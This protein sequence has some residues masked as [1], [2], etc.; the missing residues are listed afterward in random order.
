MY[1]SLALYTHTN[2]FRKILAKCAKRKYKSE[3]E[4]EREREGEKKKYQLQIA[5]KPIKFYLYFNVL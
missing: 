3:G 4:E 2:T 5:Q 1:D